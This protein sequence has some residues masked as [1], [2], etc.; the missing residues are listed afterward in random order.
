MITSTD[1]YGQ[2]HNFALDLRWILEEEA[3][4]PS[5]SFFKDLETIAE[6]PRL[7]TLKRMAEAMGKDFLELVDK[8]QIFDI[9][10]I[11]GECC[12]DA[13]FITSPSSATV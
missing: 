13:G 10:R 5:Y 2:S 4:D 6:N 9:I 11:F 3:R 1:K 12:Q 8:F 7:T